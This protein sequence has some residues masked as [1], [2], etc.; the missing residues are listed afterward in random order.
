MMKDDYTKFKIK[1]LYKSGNSHEFW[2]YSFEINNNGVSWDHCDDYNRPI[3][4]GLDNI[5][6]IFQVGCDEGLNG[7][8]E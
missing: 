1:I 5:E 4:L 7:I 6:A 3:K 2:V 8:K